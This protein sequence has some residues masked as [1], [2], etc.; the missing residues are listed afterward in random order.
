MLEN[1]THS[2]TSYFKGY[3]AAIRDQEI[4]TKFL[5]HKRRIDAGIVPS[6]NNKCRLCKWNVKDINHIISSCNQISARYYL[7]L[8]HDVIASNVLKMIMKKNHQERHVKLL[9]E[10]EYVIKIDNHEYSMS[11]KTATKISHNKP[12]LLLWDTDQKRCQVIEFNCPCDIN[13]IGKTSY[14]INTYDPLIQDL[15]ISY[16]Q[17]W[18]E[19]ISIINEAL[20]ICCKKSNNVLETTWIWTERCH[21]CN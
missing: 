10:P 3:L 15:Q 17:Y 12:D 18:S 5:K 1:K 7:P 11:I 20:G 2:M 8:C 21:L 16:P 9:S 6:V 13:L 4:P 19:M 14:K